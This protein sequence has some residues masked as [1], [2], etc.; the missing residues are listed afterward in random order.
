MIYWHWSLSIY[1]C[2]LS[3]NFA[4]F[5][6]SHPTTHGKF[7]GFLYLVIRARLT[8]RSSYTDMRSILNQE[9]STTD[10]QCIDCSWIGIY[11]R[12][13][14]MKW[15]HAWLQELHEVESLLDAGSHDKPT[16]RA[17]SWNSLSQNAR[18]CRNITVDITSMRLWSTRQARL[19]TS[20]STVLTSHGQHWIWQSSSWWRPYNIE[21][22]VHGQKYEKDTRWGQLWIPETGWNES[23]ISSPIAP[24]MPTPTKI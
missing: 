23:V 5:L 3:S 15:N 11:Q 18:D 1:L 20:V 9:V 2:L 24:S 21:S 13:S 22:C 4:W 19:K 16:Y 8:S 14:D 7:S 17:S 12:P 10:E 6:R